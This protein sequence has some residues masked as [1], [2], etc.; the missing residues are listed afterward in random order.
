MNREDIQLIVL[1]ILAEIATTEPQRQ[2]IL[3][4]MDNLRFAEAMRSRHRRHFLLRALLYVTL[5][6]LVLLALQPLAPLLIRPAIRPAPTVDVPS[7]D[8]WKPLD[9]SFRRHLS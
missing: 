6:I 4:K 8:D 1:T 2:L 5:G 9:P 7:L 3:Q